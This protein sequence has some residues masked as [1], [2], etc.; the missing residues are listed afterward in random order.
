MPYNFA[1]HLARYGPGS[2]AGPMDLARARSYCAR[3]TREHY[4]NFTVA[5][6]LLPRRL[7]PHFHPV[8]AYCRW[9][10]DLGDETG[11]GPAALELLAWW[12][13]Q[14]RDCYAGKA[15]HPVMVA[16][17]PTIDRFGIPPEPYLNLITA[18]E[19]D[20]TVNRYASFDQ[21]LNYCKNSANPVGRLV[22]YL[23]ECF[24]EERAALSDHVCTGLQLANF[25]QDVKRDAF[26]LGRV[27]LPEEDRRA[28]GYAD[29]DLAAGRFT[30]QFRELLR[31]EVDRARATLER[32]RP[33]LDLVP[34]DVRV[35][36]E[37]FLEGGLAILRGIE[38][39]DYDVWTKRPTVSKR[40]KVRLLLRAFGS[41]I[42]DRVW[43][44]G[45][46][47]P[48]PKRGGGKGTT[49][50]VNRDMSCS[51]PRFGEGQGEG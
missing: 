17:R 50:G 25:W 5:S 51:P 48:S 27:Y 7:L 22:L 42:G 44:I 23:C 34:R 40:E 11:G 1:A 14:L 20:Q 41:G 2:A 13:Q 6:V 38:A 45:R 29:A 46:K 8:Y 9:A 31:C 19:Q 26:D 28:F 43:G 10:D 12:R 32:G 4:E 36:I 35:D 21:L 24:D 39:I 15:T 47:N 18:F 49:T 30:P 33:L 3:L 37:L 16:L